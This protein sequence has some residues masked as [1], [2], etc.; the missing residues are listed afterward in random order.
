MV[1]SLYYPVEASSTQLEKLRRQIL[2]TFPQTTPPLPENIT[3]HPCEECEAV[4]EDF[5]GVR[6]W[7]A[8]DELIDVN[9]DALP[10]FTPAAY[11]YYLPA[12]FLRA[13]DEFDP[14][15][16]VLQFCLL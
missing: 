15:N 4:T 12:F 1:I 10:L 14:H 8:D 9:V 2:A 6:W 5:S 13:L 16:Q 7:C 3:S 11:H